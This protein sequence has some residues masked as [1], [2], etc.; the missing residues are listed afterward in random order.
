[1]RTLVKFADLVAMYQ[2]DVGLIRVSLAVIAVVLVLSL[3]RA[4]RN[5][6][7]SAD[8]AEAIAR[9]RIVAENAQVTRARLEAEQRALGCDQGRA[10]E[11]DE[12]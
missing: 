5:G 2:R 4:R 6:R 1:M 11:P 9:A 3:V 7:V 12:D 10:Q 8:E